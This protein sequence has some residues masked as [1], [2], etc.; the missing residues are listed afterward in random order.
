MKLVALTLALFIFASCAKTPEPPKEYK[1]GSNGGWFF[2]KPDGQ[3]VYVDKS[4]C[5]EQEEKRRA[6]E[7]KR[8]AMEAEIAKLTE[9]NDRN[10]VRTILPPDELWNMKR[11]DLDK[12]LSYAHTP[13]EK[14]NA[15]RVWLERNEEGA[16]DAAKSA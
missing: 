6:E 3:R 14:E 5:I 16:A 1:R 7:E 11:A 15:L 8:K 10:A 13:Q 2:L 4:K 9:E 12:L